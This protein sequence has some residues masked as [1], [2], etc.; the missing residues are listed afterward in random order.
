[1][2][3]KGSPRR[4]AKS[5]GGKKPEKKVKKGSPRK[6][7]ASTSAASAAAAPAAP[8]RLQQSGFLTYIKVCLKSRDQETCQQAELIN[9]HYGTLSQEEKRSLICEFYRAGAKKAGLTST[10]RQTLKVKSKAQEGD[11]QGYIS[12]GGLLQL[13]QVHIKPIY[14][15]A[16]TQH[17]LASLPLSP[18]H[19]EKQQQTWEEWGWEKSM[20]ISYSSS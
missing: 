20:N 11:W 5:L 9:Q 10:F 8:T 2:T 18:T 17:P 12:F 14:S 3:K 1:M 16:L 19:S 13:H 15:L 7:L 6:N 4:E